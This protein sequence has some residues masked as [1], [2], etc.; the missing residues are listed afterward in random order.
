MCR[1]QTYEGGIGG[2]PGVEAHG[3]Y[4]FCGMAAL[5]IVDALHHLDLRSLSV[6]ALC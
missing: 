6:F 4:G 2:C 1:S 5:A 3:G